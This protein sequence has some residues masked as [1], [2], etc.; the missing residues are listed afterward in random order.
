MIVLQSEQAEGL[1]HSSRGHRPRKWIALERSRPVRAIQLFN[2]PGMS[3]PHNRKW[4]TGG[5]NELCLGSR[6]Q[7]A[8]IRVGRCRRAYCSRA[9]LPHSFCLNLCISV[10]RWQKSVFISFPPWLNSTLRWVI[11]ANSKL[12]STAACPKS[13][14]DLDLEKLI[15]GKN[16]LQ[17]PLL[18]GLRHS[19]CPIVTGELWD[20]G[21]IQ[22]DT[23]QKNKSGGT[24]NLVAC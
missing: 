3:C 24:G 2:P 18:P 23:G 6:H 8:Q 5:P 12:K 19:F 7:P 14:V 10:P 20:T 13:T 1:N 21:Q 11:P 15:W 16:G 17:A 22:T 4:E 9:V